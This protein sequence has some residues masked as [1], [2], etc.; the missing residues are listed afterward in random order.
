MS[1]QLS[2]YLTACAMWTDALR[3]CDNFAPFR[4]LFETLDHSALVCIPW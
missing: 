2:P 3:A 4:P 1:T